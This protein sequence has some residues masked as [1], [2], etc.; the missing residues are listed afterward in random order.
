MMGFGVSWLLL[1]F[2]KSKI[3]GRKAVAAS[4]GS[5]GTETSKST[6]ALHFH[7]PLPSMSFPKPVKKCPP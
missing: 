4:F 2:K 6:R 3:K 7:Q 5:E 1:L